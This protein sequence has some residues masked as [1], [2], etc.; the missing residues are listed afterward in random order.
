[1]YWH[2]VWL[3]EG[4]PSSGWLHDTMVKKRTQ[5]HHSVKRL[6][7][8]A[9]LIQAGIL[10]EAS[11]NGDINLLKEIKRIRGGK[12]SI[13]DVPETVAGANGQEEIV[14]KFGECI[15]YTV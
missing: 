8:K 10:F 6:K 2:R 15:F 1:M 5:Y 14:E 3:G 4:R 13:P 7:R 12:D 9:K 11:M